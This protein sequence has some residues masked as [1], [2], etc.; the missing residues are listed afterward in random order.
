LLGK[1]SILENLEELK[2][3]FQEYPYIVASYLFG[4]YARGNPSEKSDLDIGVIVD[5]SAPEKRKLIGDM[6]Y[7]SYRISKFLKGKEVDI[8]IL[9]EKKPV[10]LHKVLKEGKL[11]YETN[12]T[13]R[14][15]FVWKAIQEYCDFEP[16]IRY[17]NRFYPEGYKKRLKEI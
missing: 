15:Q 14:I 4:S 13:L 11:I 3:F 10:F 6:D 12:P 1:N 8:V 9:N 5:F 17:M 2:G 7:L 16:T